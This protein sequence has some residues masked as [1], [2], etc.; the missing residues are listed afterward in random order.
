MFS[1]IWGCVSAA[2]GTVAVV[3]HLKLWPSR[4]LLH[5]TSYHEEVSRA[6]THTHSTCMHESRWA[7]PPG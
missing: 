3:K 7:R 1:R 5:L 6:G 4:R 2:S